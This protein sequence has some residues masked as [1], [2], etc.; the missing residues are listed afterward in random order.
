MN[1]TTPRADAC[2]ERLPTASAD[3]GDERMT[4]PDDMPDTGH[5]II[6]HD[7][8][9]LDFTQG[10]T[11]IIRDPRLSHGAIRLYMLLV[12]YARI[13]PGAPRSVYPSQATLAAQMGL[14]S[15]AQVRRLLLELE[16]YGIVSREEVRHPQT[17]QRRPDIIRLHDREMLS[18][19][20]T[21]PDAATQGGGHVAETDHGTCANLSGVHVAYLSGVHVAEID[22]EREVTT[23]REET[24]STPLR[25]AAGEPATTPDVEHLDLDSAQATPTP[26]RRSQ[27]QP[28]SGAT[29]L[30]TDGFDEFWTAYPRK[31]DRGHARKAW[32]KAL[33]KTNAQTI[34]DSLP[35]HKT[36]WAKSDPRFIPY[37]ATWLNG[38]H[39]ADVIEASNPPRQMWAH[40]PHVSELRFHD[41]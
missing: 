15:R 2:P 3:L 37:P 18:A 19:S 20:K 10:V 23:E 17:K 33:T 8:Y 34:L 16:T 4:T 29:P 11:A 5:P 35:T 41:E 1:A 32:V 26:R 31:K 6:Q 9:A 30:T 38:E 21:A 13:Q 22:Q 12:S 7:P 39:W 28:P 14:S 27:T 25:G 40:V 36:E 24:L